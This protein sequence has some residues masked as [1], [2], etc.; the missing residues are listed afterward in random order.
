MATMSEKIQEILA[1]MEWHQS[2]EAEQAE[3]DAWLDSPEGRGWL[4]Y[5]EA[6][7]RADQG[8]PA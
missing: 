1:P 6:S 3:F 7:A 2:D 8:I 5:G 4:E